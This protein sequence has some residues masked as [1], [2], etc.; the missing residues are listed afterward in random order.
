MTRIGC[1]LAVAVVAGAL[2]ACSPGAASV[3]PTR[4]AAPS[5]AIAPSPVAST[6]STVPPTAVASPADLPVLLTVACDGTRTTIAAPVIRPQADGVH[7]RFENSSGSAQPFTIEDV[8]G[9]EVP[10]EGGS[11]T[12][13]FGPGRHELSCAGDLVA[14]EVVDP[15]GLYRPAACAD[16]GSG[17][18]GTSDYVE[19]ATGMRGTVVEVARRQLGGL[20][21]GDVIQ[22]AGYPMASGVG[23][24]SVVVVIRHGVILAVMT[25]SPDRHGG[26]LLDTMRTCAGS[27]I[28][29]IS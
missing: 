8:G 4:T 6:P 20:A 26:W 16:T 7:I 10:V 12:Y 11:F 9:S 18:T 3:A 19:G 29:V 23:A 25:Y 2:V 27:E 15:A 13:L 24:P 17:T 14:F 28:T 22:Q 1:S 5:I 21:P